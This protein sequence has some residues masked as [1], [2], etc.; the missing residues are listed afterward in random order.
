[1]LGV[2]AG[3][4]DIMP[5]VGSFNGLAAADVTERQIIGSLRPVNHEDHIRATDVTGSGNNYNEVNQK[6]TFFSCSLK[7]SLL[8]LLSTI[9]NFQMGKGA[10]IS[11]K[12]LIKCKQNK[13]TL[14]PPPPHTHTH[15]HIKRL[16]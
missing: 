5:Q 1:M 2:P 10:R 16:K 11:R 14:P 6:H 8:S 9:S 7:H 4:I 15:P 3:G 13:K 12:G